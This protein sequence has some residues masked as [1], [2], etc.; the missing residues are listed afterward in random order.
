MEKAEKDSFEKESPSYVSY[1]VT[2][3]PSQNGSPEGVQ[4]GNS[5]GVYRI[6]RAV[7]NQGFS[8]VLV[9]QGVEI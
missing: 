9:F 3:L 1:Q 7:K 4:P 2:I 6:N 8:F 5:R